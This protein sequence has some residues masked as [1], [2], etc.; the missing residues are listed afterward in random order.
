VPLI[1]YIDKLLC[2]CISFALMFMTVGF[3][4]FNGFLYCFILLVKP[5]E[6]MNHYHYCLYPNSALYV[7]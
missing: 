6:T 7:A 3:L 5:Y 2:H 1:V 4:L